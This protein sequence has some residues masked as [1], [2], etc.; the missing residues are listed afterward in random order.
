MLPNFGHI[1]LLL[2]L[3]AQ[4]V[5]TGTE[6]NLSLPILSGCAPGPT[7]TIQLKL[8]GASHERTLCTPTFYL[9]HVRL[10]S[11]VTLFRTYAL[12]EKKQVWTTRLC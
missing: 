1:R 3:V 7:G 10:L 6:E 5:V 11:V 9:R 8:A 2:T 4:L 12:S